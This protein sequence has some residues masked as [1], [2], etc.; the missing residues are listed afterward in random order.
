M[1]GSNEKTRE[2]Q[3]CEVCGNPKLSAVLDLGTHPMCDD[4]VEIGDSRDCSEYPIEILLCGTCITAHARFQIPKTTLFPKAYHYRSRFTADVL[5]GMQ[6]LTKSCES[7]VGS[8]TQ[9]KVLDIG[10]N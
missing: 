2:I 5:S 9:K 8:L 7:R 3:T 4:L 10:C 1:T 6:Q